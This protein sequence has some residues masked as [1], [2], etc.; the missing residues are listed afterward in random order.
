ML[1]FGLGSLAFDGLKVRTPFGAGSSFWI[2]FPVSLPKSG[3]ALADASDSTLAT[4]TTNKRSVFIKRANTVI[5][6]ESHGKKHTFVFLV[7]IGVRV[8]IG[9]ACKKKHSCRSKNCGYLSTT[10]DVNGPFLALRRRLS[11]NSAMLA[12]RVLVGVLSP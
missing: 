7:F 6:R 3:I 2:N 11:S 4:T 9:G 12:A 1:R 5:P 10:D 8:V